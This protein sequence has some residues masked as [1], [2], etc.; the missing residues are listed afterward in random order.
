MPALAVSSIRP[1]G[2]DTDTESILGTFRRRWWVVPIVFVVIGGLV[3]LQDPETSVQPSYSR[4]DR[5][6]QVLDNTV[7]LSLLD[8][9]DDLLAPIPGL[10][11]QLAQLP[12]SAK[13]KALTSQYPDTRISVQRRS[14]QLA[15]QPVE[16]GESV[17]NLR[18]RVTPELGLVCLESSPKSCSL[19]L[20]G[21]ASLIETRHET[22][23]REG[24]DRLLAIVSSLESNAGNSPLLNQRLDALESAITVL[25]SQSLTSLVFIREFNA[26]EPE[27]TLTESLNYRFAIAASLILSLLVLLQWSILDKRL[28]SLRRIA[29]TVGPDHVIGHVRSESDHTDIAASAAALRRLTNDVPSLR[30][31]QLTGVNE[32]L[33]EHVIT[34]GNVHAASVR[35]DDIDAE[36]L[37]DAKTPAVIIAQRV[38]STSV[39]LAKVSD[40]LA[41]STGQRPAVLLLG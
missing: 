16:G 27:T 30:L 33:L 8:L 7:A 25:R 2:V 31:L 15:I 4:V 9:P 22:A 19:A 39:E 21:L 12:S 18:G 10:D 1:L 40:A 41:V 23:L 34:R 11:T 6:Y 13:F 37:S 28:Y 26:E 14:A 17:I 35:A 29:R 36:V 3:L 32:R 20:D 38:I 24:L 5:D